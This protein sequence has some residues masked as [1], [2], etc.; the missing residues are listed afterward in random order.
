MSGVETGSITVA[1]V[2]ALPGLGWGDDLAA[3]TTDP[4]GAVR[5]LPPNL[6]K[7]IKAARAAG[8]GAELFPCFELSWANASGLATVA[9]ALGATRVSALAVTAVSSE[10]ALTAL[11]PR[12]HLPTLQTLE[13]RLLA[14]PSSEYVD[15]PY[16][17]LLDPKALGIPIAPLAALLAGSRARALANVVLRPIVP[18][19][20]ASQKRTADEFRAQ[21]VQALP[22]GHGLD[23]VCVG[24]CALRS[25]DKWDDLAG[26]K[27][28]KAVE[29][30]F[31]DARRRGRASAARIHAASAVLLHAERD[32]PARACPLF[33][34]PYELLE[35]VLAYTAQ[36]D[37]LDERQVR[38]V[39]KQ[40][41]DRDTLRRTLGAFARHAAAGVPRSRAITEWC[42][43][44][45]L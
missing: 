28:A 21:L 2:P 19:M 37:V 22:Q 1:L 44:G 41:G 38:G 40:A 17:T 39:I 4:F 29:K 42:V 5:A 35:S 13:F 10:D 15:F 30:H 23:G 12:L 24:L 27:C 3:E 26:C 18:N 33:E 34:L 9:N 16:P 31:S 7:E 8:H 43:N 25:A 6:A 11:L 36:D 14:S 45:G 20:L 32:D